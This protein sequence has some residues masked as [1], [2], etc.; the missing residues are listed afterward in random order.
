MNTKYC[1]Y[2]AN[3]TPEYIERKMEEYR[4]ITEVM[5]RAKIRKKRLKAIIEKYAAT[6]E[7]APMHGIE[8]GI[9]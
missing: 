7:S 3:R 8:R 1:L 2:T 9:I 4:E 5:N 6:H